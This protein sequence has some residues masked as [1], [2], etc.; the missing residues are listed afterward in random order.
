MPDAPPDLDDLR[1]LAHD[2]GLP[3]ADQVDAAA[4]RHTYRLYLV[5]QGMRLRELERVVG[6]E[7][8]ARL[9]ALAAYSPKGPGK[10]LEDVEL[11]YPLPD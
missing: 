9:T 2:A 7:P 11:V 10:P 4:L 8:R 5:R 3:L 6:P 1:L